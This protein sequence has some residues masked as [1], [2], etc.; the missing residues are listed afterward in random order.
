MVS[1]VAVMKDLNLSNCQEEAD[2]KII[3]HCTNVLHRNHGENVCIWS[4]SG[5]KDKIVLAAGLLE[6]L[7]DRFFVVN[8]S[9]S[10][11]EHHKLSD[12]DIDIESASALLGLHAFTGDDYMS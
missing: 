2:T 8:G 12:F 7:N 9:G 1:R 3:L 5:D 10:N 6:E 11:K 4:S